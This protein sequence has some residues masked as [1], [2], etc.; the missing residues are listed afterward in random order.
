M[1]HETLREVVKGYMYSLSAKIQEKFPDELDSGSIIY[2]QDFSNNV[3]IMRKEQWDNC[4]CGAYNEENWGNDE[5]ECTCDFRN[6][7]FAFDGSFSCNWYKHINRSFE[8]SD[9]PLDAWTSIFVRC[10]DSLR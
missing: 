4:S 3:F 7:V 5:I 9:M 10:Y 2:G 1:K 6:F 8:C